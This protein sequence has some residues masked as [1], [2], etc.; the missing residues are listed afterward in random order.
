MKIALITAIFGGIDEIKEVPEQT[1]VHY[2]RFVYTEKN[3]PF[4]LPN[5]CPRLQAKYFRC[6]SH[7]IDE[8]K[9]Y[10]MHCWLDGRITVTNPEMLR[11]FSYRIMGSDIGLG[12]HQDRNCIYDEADFIVSNEGDYLKSRYG[13]QPIKAEVDFYRAKGHPINWGLWSSGIFIRWN[14]ARV[15]EMFNE[16]WD[17]CL[18]W[19][20]FDQT[21]LP[22]VLRKNKAVIA[23]LEYVHVVSNKYFELGK[24]LSVGKE[25]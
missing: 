15:N 4:P 17:C 16:W 10:D 23:D 18:T 21:A 11:D 7:R 14:N 22:Y 2:K 13:S 5:L 24:H 25:Q 6:Q 19:S 12:T 20:Y 9:E 8:L 1:D 3:S